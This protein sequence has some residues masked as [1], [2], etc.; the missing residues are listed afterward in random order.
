MALKC[1]QK[2]ADAQSCPCEKYLRTEG[3]FQA[4]AWDPTDIIYLY[5]LSEP[6]DNSQGPP[7]CSGSRPHWLDY[8][9][10]QVFR[11]LNGLPAE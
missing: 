2:R 7:E 1:K 6:Q 10:F 3:C 5:E 9:S 4:M 11:I 8:L